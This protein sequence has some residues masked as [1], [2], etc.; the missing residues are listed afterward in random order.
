M[1]NRKPNDETPDEPTQAAEPEQAVKETA[2]DPEPPKV[3]ANCGKPAT[4]VSS[5][6]NVSPAYY[7][8]EHGS[9]EPT[10]PL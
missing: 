2:G 10:N 1:P 6:P 8:D 5:S 7:C 4:R 9:N 3:C